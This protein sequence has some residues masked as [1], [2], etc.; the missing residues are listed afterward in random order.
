[1]TAISIL[2]RWTQYSDGLRK[3][4]CGLIRAVD[5]QTIHSA[6]GGS[7]LSDLPA[8]ANAI[9]GVTTSAPRRSKRQYLSQSTGS[10]SL[11]QRAPSVRFYRL[12]PTRAAARPAIACSGMRHS[13]QPPRSGCLLTFCSTSKCCLHR[14]VRWTQRSHRQA[15]QAP[16]HS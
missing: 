15:S 4:S 2:R 14:P 13:A 3:T 11:L 7:L 9:S 5:S 1:M 8:R 16:P 10:R 6:H 12:P